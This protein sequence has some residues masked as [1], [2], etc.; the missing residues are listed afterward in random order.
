MKTLPIPA[1]AGL[2]LT[3]ASALSSC[4]S[5][6]S[7]ETAMSSVPESSVIP[8]SAAEA[9]ARRFSPIVQGAWVNAGY[10]A[11]LQKSGSPRQ[12]QEKI[13]GISEL[14]IKPEARSGDSLVA[15]AGINDH[16]GG[17]LRVYF[18]AGQQPN[19]LVTNDPYYGAAGS[20]GELRYQLSSAD[21]TLTLTTYTK[22]RK[23]LTLKTYS[24]VRGAQPDELAA[25]NYVV[26]QRLLVGQYAGRDSLG[27]AVHLEFLADGRVKGLKG[28]RKYH[29]HTDFFGGPGLDIDF[30]SLDPG[31][32]HS[33]DMGYRRHGDTLQLY[34]ARL[35]PPQRLPGAADDYSMPQL[36]RGRRLFT[37]VKR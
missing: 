3:T 32:R 4:H 19:S 28:F 31:T 36:V 17:S 1:W 22:A 23:V 15:G 18:R 27:R 5:T 21:T 14:F 12:A 9:L 20:F 30:L 6:K 8:G 10:L 13:E 33:R 29:V 7:E 35:I 16:E 37:L 2:L 11:A 26:R 24:R 34:V 25:L